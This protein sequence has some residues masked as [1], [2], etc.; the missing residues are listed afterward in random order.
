MRSGKRLAIA[1]VVSIAITATVIGLEIALKCR[2]PQSEGCMW[3]KAFFPQLTVPLYSA[4][5]GLPAF[6]L[7][8][9][10]LRLRAPQS[11]RGSSD[12]I[13]TKSS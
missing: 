11:P 2:L 4:M 6:G 3:A 1:G 9:W 8:F 13:A 12:D 10:L 5:I 7:S